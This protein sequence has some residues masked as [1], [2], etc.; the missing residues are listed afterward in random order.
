M[1]KKDTVKATNCQGCIKKENITDY[2]IFLVW[3][4]CIR[5]SDIDTQVYFRICYYINKYFTVKFSRR[6]RRHY[7]KAALFPFMLITAQPVYVRAWH[8]RLHFTSSLIGLRF[9][10]FV[11]VKFS[12]YPPIWLYN[13]GLSPWSIHFNGSRHRTLPVCMCRWP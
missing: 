9:H 3:V 2:L 7:I 13:I 11:C 6:A 12:F 1:Q 10:V 4:Y 5:S 8:V